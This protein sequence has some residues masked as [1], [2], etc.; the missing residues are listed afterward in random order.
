MAKKEQEEL[1]EQ[2]KERYY[3]SAEVMTDG[4]HG[5][6]GDRV[7]HVSPCE[8][9]ETATVNNGKKFGITKYGSLCKIATRYNPVLKQEEEVWEPTG[10][11]YFEDL[12]DKEIIQLTFA[13]IIEL[14]EKQSEYFKKIY[15]KK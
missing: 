12:T 1:Q 15:N 13:K 8:R 4:Y 10:I 14:N 11:D 6:W 2:K 5:V 9:G 7:I 3:L